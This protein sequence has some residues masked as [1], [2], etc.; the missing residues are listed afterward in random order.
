MHK[1][2]YTALLF[3]LLAISGKKKKI[4]CDE[5]ILVEFLFLFPCDI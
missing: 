2:L 1:I 5:I 3:R 4:Q